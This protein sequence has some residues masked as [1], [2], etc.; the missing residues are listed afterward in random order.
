KRIENKKNYGV[1]V[2]AEGL[3]ESVKDELRVI[4][5][6][7]HGKYGTYQT[8]E[9]DNLRMGE[10]EFGKL[11]RDL[12]MERLAAP[13][14]KDTTPARLHAMLDRKIVPYGLDVKFISKDLGYELRSA[15]PIPFDAEYTRD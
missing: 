11:V 1:I 3:I 15:D 13:D 9:F 8:D 14:A 6:K 7:T 5:D 10:I 2:L 4:L 12:L